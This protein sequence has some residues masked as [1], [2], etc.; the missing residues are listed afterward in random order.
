MDFIMGLPLVEGYNALWVIV[1][2]FTKIAHFV[3]CTNTIGPSNLVDGFLTHVVWAYRLPNSIVLD[4]GSLFT[5]TFW[6]QIMEAMGTTRN[7]STSFHPE[8]DGQTEYT[9]A[10]LE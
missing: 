8:I 2:R 9:N 4:R 5:S 7:L 3:T 6:T 1:D 10:I